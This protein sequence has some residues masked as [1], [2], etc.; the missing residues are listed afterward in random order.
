M[1]TFKTT[2]YMSVEETLGDIGQSIRDY[3][4]Q[5]NLEQTTLAER[6]GISVGALQNLESGR[7]CSLATLVKVMRALG[8]GD[9]HKTLAPVATVNPLT[10]V[11]RSAERRLRASRLRMK[12]SDR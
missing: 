11:Q 5:K 1:R 8:R 4:L 7:G 3:R 12:Q 10:M 2:P 9:W 6:A